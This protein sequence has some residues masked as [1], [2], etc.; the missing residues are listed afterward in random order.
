MYKSRYPILILA[1][2]L[3]LAGRA[4]AQG[5][6]TGTLS[7]S[8]TST[9][10]LSLPGVTVSI[11]SDALLGVRTAVT[12]THG[13]YIFR[14][15][16]PGLYHVSF[17]MSGFSPLER[18][19]SVALGATV[20]A[21]AT[22]QIATV[23]ETVT[24][25][26]EEATPLATTEVGANYKQD[27]IDTLPTPRTV[28]GVAQLAPGLTTNTPNAEQVQIAG[29][30][31]YDN[32]FLIDGVDVNDNLFG[33]AND[34]FIEDAIQETQVLTSGISAEYG[35]FGG[36]VVNT[37][38]KSGGNKPSGSFRVN[39]SD[40]A[41]RD[42]TPI[43]QQ[44]G[45]SRQNDLN[46]FYEATLGGPIVKDRLWFFLAGRSESSNTQLTLPESGL[47]FTQTRDQ[48][49]GEAKLT[50]AITPN[51]TISATFTDVSDKIYRT[52]FDF[53]ID[54][55]H[56]AYNAKQPN[57]LL[58][59]SYNG[60]LRS[61][62]S[63]EAQYSQ[64]KFEFQNSGG[65]STNIAD[66]PY[67]AQSV[68]AAYNAPYFDASDPE[69][70]NNRQ[71]AGSLSYFLS[72]K[73]FG[74]HDIKIGF[75]NYQSK[76]TGGN[77]QSSTGYVFYTDY[78]TDAAGKP[79]FD[80]NGYVVPQFTPGVSQLQNWQAVKGAEVTIA[81]T[82]AYVND[83]V[84]I[85]KRWSFNLGARAEWVRGD[86]TAGI[87]PVSAS[88]I[89][90]RLGASFDVLGNGK[91]KLDGTYSQ[92]AGK[93]SE[94]QFAN[95]TNVGNPNAI[96]YLYTGPAGQG[97]DFAPGINPANYT[98]VIGGSF[99]TA[100]VLYGKNIKSP[101]TKEWSAAVGL[102]LGHGGYLKGIYIHR[103]VDDF[104]QEFID[105]ATGT[106]DVAVNGID[107]GTFS[108]RLWANDN[109][110]VRTYSAIELQGAYH[111]A[112]HWDLNAHY[113]LMLKDDGNQEGEAPNQPGAPS[114]FS[115]YYP[116]LFSEAR[117][118]PVGPL[119]GF[120]RHR[121]RAWTTYDLKLGRAGDASFG[122]LYSYDSGIAYSLRSVGQP[123]TP[124]QKA[125]GASLYPDLPQSQTIFYGAGRGSEF[126]QGASL[127][128]A[129]LVYGIPVW[130]SA[131][132]WVKFEVDNIFDSTP[133]IS[134]NIATQPD[135]NSPTD[136]LGLPTGYIKGSQ[137]GKGTST[138]NYP[139]PREY[140]VSLGFRF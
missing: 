78:L 17:A 11:K 38:T 92:Y 27:M 16:P 87:K 126:F 96:Y 42:K 107:F 74:R 82:S 7:G 32:V 30:F 55:L 59:L 14:A 43:E 6:Q 56:D 103:S 128:N 18:A 84:A 105:Q 100:N 62:L 139:F 136:A 123:L 111:P 50:G 132:P 29:N 130:K 54:P 118:Y 71:I 60:T 109:T 20:P 25:V 131:R 66:S 28:F 98:Q 93:Y 80:A 83:R 140:L 37:I 81:T 85:G 3:A 52:P 72:T 31:A 2:A 39:F 112:P 33:T 40:P 47:P 75:E 57:G 137:F 95:N 119:S 77:S 65:T 26:A 23:S 101:V 73:G 121:L 19:V 70:R 8:V 67:I 86:A 68:L 13:G 88:R 4:F 35:R 115:G 99:P 44:Q 64:K 1:F 10:G 63:I 79:V 104:V 51:H 91:I 135:P 124:T 48:K 90:P 46:K 122:L 24:V 9:D 129:S 108:N 89:V 15:L 58:V 138:S 22:L 21:D 120:E 12:D 69:A 114:V 117:N 106:T 102:D 36:G 127:F 53:D 94:A 49:R 116:E 5:T 41:W 45:I 125:I 110:G 133:L 76:H 97:R 113:T 134:Y 61:N 34:L